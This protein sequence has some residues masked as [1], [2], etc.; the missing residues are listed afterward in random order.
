MCPVFPLLDLRRQ[1]QYVICQVVFIEIESPI[2]M[3]V[4]TCVFVSDRGYIERN[5]SDKKQ[6]R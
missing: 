4:S 2:V 1:M 6:G 3:M 5:M